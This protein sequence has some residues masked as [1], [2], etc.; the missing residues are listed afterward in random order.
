MS[1]DST[2]DA[3]LATLVSDIKN[4]QNEKGTNQGEWSLNYTSPK[5]K[6]VAKSFTVSKNSQGQYQVNDIHTSILQKFW[7]IF[8]GRSKEATDLTTRLNFHQYQVSATQNH[9]PNHNEHD[10]DSGLNHLMNQAERGFR[11]LIGDAVFEPVRSFGTPVQVIGAA[12]GDK[13]VLSPALQQFRGWAIKNP[14]QMNDGLVA[15]ISQQ[16]NIAPMGSHVKH[17]LLSALDTRNAYLKPEE[18]TCLQAAERLI[19]YET[20]RASDLRSWAK[21]INL[22]VDS[23][24][25]QQICRDVRVGELGNPAYVQQELK[26]AIYGNAELTYNQNILLN[27]MER[28]YVQRANSAQRE[29]FNRSNAK[30]LVRQLNE[31]GYQITDGICERIAALPEIEKIGDAGFVKHLLNKSLNSPESSFSREQVLCLNVARKVI[32]EQYRSFQGW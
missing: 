22:Q 31:A 16:P 4:E 25:A 20:R 23:S 19:S 18:V 21:S 14:Y 17:H 26:N 5:G 28:A 9:I 27:A 7:A 24:L 13:Y 32:N 11:N 30:N 2:Y 8:G 12:P 1:I 10:F 3:R 6:A 29:E 15:V